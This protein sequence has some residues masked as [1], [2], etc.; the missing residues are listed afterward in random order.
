MIHVIGMA[1]SYLD[2]RGAKARNL[3]LDFRHLAETVKTLRQ[4]GEQAFGV[5]LVLNESV[6]RRANGWRQ[7]YG[8]SDGI[9]VILVTISATE[10][11]AVE[12]EKIRNAKANVKGALPTD[13]SAAIS[14][15]V[16][17]RHLAAE[18]SRRF[19]G[20]KKQHPTHAQLTSVSW[21]FYGIVEGVSK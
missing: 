19:P 8:I 18:I 9:E 17:E 20:I 10:Q 14:Q 13:A 15:E 5:M 12:C 3:E 6:R 1:K 4:S 16:G 7:K 11:T 2:L 21:D